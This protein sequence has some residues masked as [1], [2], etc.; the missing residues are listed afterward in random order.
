MS[1][2]ILSIMIMP[3]KISD[4]K[5]RNF[6]HNSLLGDCVYDNYVFRDS[7]N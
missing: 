7:E 2:Q 1:S 5:S 3:I 6:E 4:I